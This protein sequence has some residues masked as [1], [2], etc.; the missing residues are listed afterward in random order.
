MGIYDFFKGKCPHCDGNIDEYDGE[1]YGDIQTK[2][3][4]PQPSAC[5][6]SFWP[7]GKLPFAPPIKRICI[8][9][10][11]CCDTMIDAIFEGDTLLRYEVTD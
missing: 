2:M 6:R 8:G 11:S 10:T 4:W 1:P 7:G 5:F 9:K 3:F